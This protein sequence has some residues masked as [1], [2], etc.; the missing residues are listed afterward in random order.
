MI[1]G[2]SGGSEPGNVSVSQ[3]GVTWYSFTT[4][5]NF[6]ADDP[7]FIKLAAEVED[8][9]FCDGFAP[10]LGRVY[11][12]CHA[13]ASI[14]EWNLWWAEPANPTLPVDPNLSFQALAGRSVARVAQTYGDS[15]GGTGYDIARLDLP[16][17]PDRR[18][19]FCTFAS[20]TSRRRRTGD[21]CGRT[22]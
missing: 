10:T 21:R 6:M 9:P 1:V 12:P 17:D 22:T 3:D 13:D 2:A 4:D 8:G 20:T 18:Q 5:P 7:N 11:D 19:V 16:L 15:A 14:G